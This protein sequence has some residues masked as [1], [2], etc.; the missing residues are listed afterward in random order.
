MH[1]EIRNKTVLI[2]GGSRGIGRACAESFAEEGCSLH[3]AARDPKVL[4]QTK[5][6]LESRYGV[7][8]TTHAGDLTRSDWVHALAEA[9][10]DIDILVNNAGAIPSGDLW[11]IDELKWRQAWDLKVF[12]YINLCRELYPRLR[13][14]GKGVIINIIGA[15]GERP[16]TNYIVGGSGN[17]A[18]MAFTKALGGRSMRDGVRVIGV[19]PGL[20]KTERL[21]KILR[22][23]ATSK[24]ND[25]ERWLEFVPKDYPPGEP[26][27]VANLVVFLASDRAKNISG[28]VI[29]VDGGISAS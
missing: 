21:E 16:A 1:L 13:D 23:V 17:A 7:A 24:L 22:S 28:T 14:R 3:L 10:A 26:A 15:A 2:T 20:I 18:L 19:N 29:T 8:V 11:Q 9:C 27:D 5:N 12:G 4:E 25:P 6:Y